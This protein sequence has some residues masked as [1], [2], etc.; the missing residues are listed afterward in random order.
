MEIYLI[1]PLKELVTARPR[2]VRAADLQALA[3]KIKKN[4]APHQHPTD[5]MRTQ[6]YV[7][8]LESL[9]RA[10]PAPGWS[11]N[12]LITRVNKILRADNYYYLHKIQPRAHDNYFYLENKLAKVAGGKNL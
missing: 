6:K 4:A 5:F 2:R 8:I 3:A 9:I 11:V 12:Q 1:D 7:T 10:V